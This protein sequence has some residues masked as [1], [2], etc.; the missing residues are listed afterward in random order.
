MVLHSSQRV[1]I[2]IAGWDEKM[3]HNEVPCPKLVLH[4]AS[5]ESS[6]LPRTG[7]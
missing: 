2:R 7:P 1:S 4:D 5:N 6:S 3:F